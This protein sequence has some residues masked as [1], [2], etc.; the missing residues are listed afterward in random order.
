[1]SI[2]VCVTFDL[3]ENAGMHELSALLEDLHCL[4]RPIA[5]IGLPR[6][7]V[8]TELAMDDENA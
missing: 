1:M 3:G 6:K 5:W 2:T 4:G 8:G 7:I